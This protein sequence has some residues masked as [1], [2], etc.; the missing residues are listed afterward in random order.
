MGKSVWY[1]VKEIK[2]SKSGK[3]KLKAKVLDTWSKTKDCKPG[4]EE[5]AQCY[6]QVIILFKNDK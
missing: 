4:C 6:T 1:A 5:H 2:D 3:V